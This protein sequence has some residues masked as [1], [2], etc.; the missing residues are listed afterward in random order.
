MTRRAP[1][2]IVLAFLTML[3]SAFAVQPGE[4]SPL[5]QLEAGELA[6]IRSQSQ[7]ETRRAASLI[8]QGAR[9]AIASGDD[10]TAASACLALASITRNPIVATDLRDLAVILDPQRT[11]D[12]DLETTPNNQDNTDALEF[13]TEARLNASQDA[14]SRYADPEIRNKVLAATEPTG[15]SERETDAMIAAILERNDSDRCRGHVYVA[16]PDE[17]GQRVVCP[18]H[19]RGIGL[20]A[21]DDELRALVTAELLL[22]GTDPASFESSA[23]SGMTGP[24]RIPDLDA[25]LDAVDSP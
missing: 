12:Q 1:L 18:D 7:E 23:A 14:A 13:L 3:L 20:A 6:A 5:K 16:D 15:M 25:I 11:I 8:A 10:T 2:A 17:R 21:N 22:I 24:I 4:P 9:A 19:L